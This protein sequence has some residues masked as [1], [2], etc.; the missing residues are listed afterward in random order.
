MENT[1][2]DGT[3]NGDGV[4][5]DDNDEKLTNDDE[6]EEKLGAD[7]SDGERLPE[8]ATNAYNALLIGAL[9]LIVGMIVFMIRRKVTVKE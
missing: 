6:K 7:G 5:D 1:N 3:G 4:S 9:L 2:G 8:T